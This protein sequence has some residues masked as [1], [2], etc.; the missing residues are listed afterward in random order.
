MPKKVCETV[1]LIVV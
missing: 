1:S